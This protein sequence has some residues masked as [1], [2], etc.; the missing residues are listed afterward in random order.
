MGGRINRKKLRKFTTLLAVLLV[1]IDKPK[2]DSFSVKMFYCATCATDIEV[3]SV[4][5]VRRHLRS[6]LKYA[7][8]IFSIQCRQ[9]QCKSSFSNVDSYCKHFSLNHSNCS[10]DRRVRELGIR[11]RFFAAIF[12]L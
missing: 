2:I 3:S 12:A 9:G 11:L 7:L 10:S 8:L 5:C 4:R 6:Y 1:V